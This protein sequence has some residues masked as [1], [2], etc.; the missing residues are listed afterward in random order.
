MNK[1]LGALVLAGLQFATIN[2]ASTGFDAT[3]GR[4]Y[5][6]RLLFED[7]SRPAICLLASSCS[8]STST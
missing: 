7:S 2:A 1:T 5:I 4:T 8:T 6:A 3:N